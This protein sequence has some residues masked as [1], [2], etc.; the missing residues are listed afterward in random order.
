MPVSVIKPWQDL[1][2]RGGAGV[3]HDVRY[4][5]FMVRFVYLSVLRARWQ[6]KNHGETT[7][8]S[9]P[10]CTGTQNTACQVGARNENGPLM[11]QIHAD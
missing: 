7:F 10:E 2:Q 4:V 9:T 1:S 3:E 5:L 8:E 6:M 11:A